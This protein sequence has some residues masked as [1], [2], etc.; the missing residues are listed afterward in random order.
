M[1]LIQIQPLILVFTRRAG[2]MNKG[3]YYL[4]NE[5]PQERLCLAGGAGWSGD[6]LRSACSSSPFMPTVAAAEGCFE[7]TRKYVQERKAFGGLATVF[8]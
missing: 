4:M 2:E 8:H 1:T 6:L 3:F 7:N 5:L